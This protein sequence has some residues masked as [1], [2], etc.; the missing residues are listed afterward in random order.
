MN[1]LHTFIFW[2]TT[3]ALGWLILLSFVRV[4]STRGHRVFPS[5]ELLVVVGLTSITI[6]LPLMDS[7]MSSRT[8]EYVEAGLS[9]IESAVDRFSQDSEPP[10]VTGVHPDPA[11][12]NLVRVTFS[13]PVTCT[14]KIALITR[15]RVTS[16]WTQDCTGEP[17]SDITFRFNKPLEPGTQIT[18]FATTSGFRI[19][20]VDG[21]PLSSHAFAPVV[22][23]GR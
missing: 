13:K 1:A 5:R 23:H 18:Q 16:M 15:A 7:T 22:V 10:R 3:L 12:P 9:Y 2:L 17:R 20:S 8:S 4:T 14:G 19:A 6:G 21:E 11:S